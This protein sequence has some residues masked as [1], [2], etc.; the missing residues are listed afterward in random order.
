VYLSAL[1]LGT[2]LHYLVQKNPM[3]EEH[4]RRMEE[5]HNFMEL[6]QAPCPLRV[7]DVCKARNIKRAAF[8]AV[9]NPEPSTRNP[10]PET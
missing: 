3:E 9:E 5:Q 10:T 7:L 2:L 1:I 4:K 6:K 8:G